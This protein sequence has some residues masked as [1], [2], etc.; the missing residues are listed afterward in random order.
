MIVFLDLEASGL[1]HDSFPIEVGWC[2]ADGQGESHLIRPE[3]SWD[4]W[5]LEAERLHGLSLRQLRQDGEPA[6]VVARRV[7]AVLE[8]SDFF[9]DAP[10]FD[11]AWLNKLLH[12]CGFDIWSAPVW[13][14]TD[15]YAK[16]CA[17]LRQHLATEHEVRIL[18]ARIV[19]EA[20]EA[21]GRLEHVRHRALPDAQGLAWTWRDV[22]RRVRE[23]TGE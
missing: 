13:S 2:D 19:A 14:V 11:G 7:I 16:A 17:L 20:E 6:E 21:E 3:P 22:R 18:S 8:N 9:S 15:V 1:H 4:D 12:T 10:A 5:S 23:I